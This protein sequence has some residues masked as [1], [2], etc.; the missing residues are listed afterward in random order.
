MK[1]KPCYFRFK[2][3]L[4]PLSV[5]DNYI[6]VNLA[7]S[8]TFCHLYGIEYGTSE[9]I[10]DLIKTLNFPVT[11]ITI[12]IEATTIQSSWKDIKWILDT[13]PSVKLII[14]LNSLKVNDTAFDLL[15]LRNDADKNKLLYN[16]DKT[17]Y[18]EFVDVS[19]TAGSPLLYFN[20]TPRDASDIIWSH[21]TD[22]WNLLN[23]ATQGKVEADWTL[24]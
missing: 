10:S 11:K 12:E 9:Y 19:S 3:E 6:G 7:I 14:S 13:N 23:T 15:L 24:S 2:K 8:K 18:Q 17:M 4:S 1:K 22:T 16:I 20:I 21:N 5:K